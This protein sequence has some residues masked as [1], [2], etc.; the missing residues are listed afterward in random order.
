MRQLRFDQRTRARRPQVQG[1][2]GRAIRP[3]R[4]GRKSEIAVLDAIPGAPFS[5]CAGFKEPHARAR[6]APLTLFSCWPRPR[7]NAPTWC[8]LTEKDENMRDLTS[9]ELDQCTG[10]VFIPIRGPE[11]A[12]GGKFKVG[13]VEP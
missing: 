8:R 7:D 11:P 6:C 1:G 13:V 12:D 2:G 4:S 5:R 9:P 10:G 3:D